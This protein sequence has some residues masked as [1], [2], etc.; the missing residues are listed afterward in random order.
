MGQGVT[1]G[2]RLYWRSRWAGMGRGVCVHRYGFLF[3]L[4]T[5]WALGCGQ[6]TLPCSSAD[7]SE[8]KSRYLLQ[9]LTVFVYIG[10][11]TATEWTCQVQPEI[12]NTYV[13]GEMCDTPMAPMTHC[14]TR[15][16]SLHSGERPAVE[17]H[18]E[19]QSNLA[20]RLAL[21]LHA[22]YISI[23]SAVFHESL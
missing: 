16:P 17:D 11:V 14:S 4:V 15:V 12:S 5:G 13:N 6:G 2:S 22:V 10:Y 21:L 8:L 9:T 19:R 20:P 18:G 23:D 1:S 3:T 7:E